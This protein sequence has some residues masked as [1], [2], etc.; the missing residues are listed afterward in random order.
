MMKTHFMVIIGMLVGI[1]LFGCHKENQN[2]EPKIT[3]KSPEISSTQA[4]FEWT[5]DYLGKICSMV[6]VGRNEDMSDATR[7]GSEAETSDKNFCATATRLE[8]NTQY[9]YRYVVWNPHNHFEME[10]KPFTTK[11]II[12]PT[13]VT[14]SVT[15]VTSSSAMCDGEVTDDGNDEVTERGICWGTN[16]NP[17]ITGS[18]ASSGTG[19]GTFTVQM[20]GLMEATS[21]YVRAYAINSSG[22][23]YGGEK[24]I[25]S[26]TVATLDV[27]EITSSSAVCRGEVTDDSEAEVI[28]RGICWGTSP[29]PDITGSHA[30]SGTGLGTFTVKM[31]GLMDATT[32]YVRAYAINCR[33]TGYGNEKLF[34]PHEP[35]VLNGRFSVSNNEQVHF[36]SGNLQYQASTNTW[37]F[38]EHQYDNVGSDNQN[39][40]SSYSGWIDLFGWGT[41]GWRSGAI[42]YQPWSVSTNYNGYNPGGSSTNNLTGDYANADW[43]VYNAISNG[44]NQAGMWRTL[45]TE[46]WR[47]VLEERETSSG[48]RFAK[49]SVNS[50]NGLILLPDDWNSSY[51]ALNNTNNGEAA[52]G[53][54]FITDAQ[55]NATLEPH[56]A[57]FFPVTRYRCGDLIYGDGS[58]GN[59]WSVSYSDEDCAFCMCFGS[60][61]MSSQNGSYRRLCGFAVRVVRSAQD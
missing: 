28:E 21:Y 38:A 1:V 58:G 4:V 32:Y 44:G 31:T 61:G 17:D 5:V 41:S 43:G 27:M 60:L 47:Y 39:I 36:S 57:V 15:N 34:F 19:L 37:R 6:E 33:G 8:Q 55:W 20:T 49:A 12:K 50:V 29:N 14:A 10:V 23:G 13:V 3:E 22:I 56:G 45:T 46:E 53:S 2:K 51:Y 24:S 11:A 40:S 16:P 9:Y 42:C 35:G 25:T 30:S 26:P 7:Y 54:N 52:Y 18:H 48:I 59:Y